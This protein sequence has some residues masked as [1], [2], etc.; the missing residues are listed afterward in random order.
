MTVQPIKYEINK[1]GFRL[2]KRQKIRECCARSFTEARPP[3]QH[4]ASNCC[5][6]GTELSPSRWSA[7]AVEVVRC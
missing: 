4:R 3:A 6:P 5:T 7:Q 2:A 1:M